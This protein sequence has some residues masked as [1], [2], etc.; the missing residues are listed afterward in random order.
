MY[1]VHNV[2]PVTAQKVVSR[3]GGAHFKALFQHFVLQSKLFV[4]SFD[5]KV[6]NY[7]EKRRFQ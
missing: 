2:E 3:H 4:P 1:P 6:H 7:L 5:S